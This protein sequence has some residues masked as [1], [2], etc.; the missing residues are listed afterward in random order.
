M[1]RGVAFRASDKWRDAYFGLE[2]IP[3]KEYT[4][5]VDVSDAVSYVWRAVIEYRGFHFGARHGYTIRHSRVE[6]NVNYVKE[7]EIFTLC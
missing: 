6:L 2:K 5:V 1:H 7:E 3:E 4:V